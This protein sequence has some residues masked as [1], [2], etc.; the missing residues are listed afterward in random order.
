M[1]PIRI[2]VHQS[3]EMGNVFTLLEPLVCEGITVPAGFK[4]DGA[5]V[6]RFFW[7]VVFPPGDTKA[8]LAAFVHDFIYRTHPAGWTRAAA[9][10][11]FRKLLLEGGVPKHS[12][13]IAYLGVRLFGSSSWQAGGQNE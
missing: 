1:R 9:D 2:E 10:N 11:L 6:P 7:R 8:L 3:D 4:S 13:D 12:A 5:S